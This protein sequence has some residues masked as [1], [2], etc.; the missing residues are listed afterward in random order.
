MQSLEAIKHPGPGQG[1]ACVHCISLHFVLSSTT[2]YHTLYISYYPDINH[3]VLSCA[4]TLYYL[5]C[6]WIFFCGQRCRMVRCLIYLTHSFWTN[7]ICF[8]KILNCD[9][10]RTDLGTKA[11][12]VHLWQIML[13]TNQK[14][15]PQK[16]NQNGPCKGEK[17]CKGS[18][19]DN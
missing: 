4:C 17:N 11:F 15:T 12:P 16:T 3:T 13:K 8:W 19:K 1:P 2:L 5:F 18:S 6:T 7:H 10:F 9:I 14:R